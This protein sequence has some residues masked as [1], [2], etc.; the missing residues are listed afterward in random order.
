LNGANTF[1][2]GVM[3]NDG[4]TVIVASESNL[5]GSNGTLTVTSAVTSSKSV[6]ITGA[7]AGFGIGSALLGSIVTGWNG[8]VATLADFPTINISSPSAV[9]WATSAAVSLNG[10]TLA[11]TESFTMEQS[12]AAGGVGGAA[13]VKRNI[14]L[15]AYG[16]TIDVASGKNLTVTGVVSSQATDELGGLTKVGDGTLTLSGNNTYVGGTKL[17]A[18]VLAL[19]NAGALGTKGR[20]EFNGG[21]LKY[22]AN[23]ATDY[24]NRFSDKAG[25]AFKV[26]TNGRNITFA[27]EL[28]S[29]GGGLTVGD[30]SGTGSLTLTKANSYTG[31]TT[32]MGGTLKANLVAAISNSSA[33]NVNA[34]ARLDLSAISNYSTGT[35]QRFG[36]SGTVLAQSLTIQGGFQTHDSVHGTGTLNVTNT[37][38]LTFANG[39]HYTMNIGL[40]GADSLVASGAV[41]LGL[42]SSDRITLSLNLTSQVLEGTTYTFMTAGSGLLENNG[43]FVYNGIALGDN[44]VF[45]VAGDGFAQYFRLSYGTTSNTLTAMEAIPE[46]GTWV[47]LVAGAGTLGLVQRMRRRNS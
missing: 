20:I 7:P 13:A 18:G 25:Q 15:G 14:G 8:S 40:T 29:T 26:D 4:S 41:K 10:G 21:T 23:N 30:S 44:A 43:L 5:A 45:E 12:N 17:N 9:S 28:K 16:G 2:Q 42:V 36:G 46:P 38:A 11:V 31:E 6:T 3:V 27:S 34:G 19:D 22:G 39:A 24:S 32:V 1:S 35:A 37:G 33:I 47:M